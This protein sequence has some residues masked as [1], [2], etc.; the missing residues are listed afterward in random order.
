MLANQ[1]AREKR[2][3]LVKTKYIIIGDKST[4]TFWVLDFE[5][6]S[7]HFSLPGRIHEN[8]FPLSQ[9]P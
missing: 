7:H 2:C 4:E 1:R 5:V 8:N 3:S 6:D 9:C